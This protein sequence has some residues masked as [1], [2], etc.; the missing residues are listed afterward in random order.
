MNI[1]A[2]ILTN[3]VTD[4]VTNIEEE[5]QPS[6]EGGARSLPATP[7]RLQR[8]QNPKW[9]PGG[10]KMADGVWKGVYP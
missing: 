9:P 1:V 8:L 3:K 6:G 2:N 5:Y 4:I 10:P 7:N